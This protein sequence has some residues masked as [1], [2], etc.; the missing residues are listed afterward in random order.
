MAPTRA[1]QVGF[2]VKDAPDDMQLYFRPGDVVTLT[3]VP[4]EVI[5]TYLST[6]TN[7][8]VNIEMLQQR[9]VIPSTSTNPRWIPLDG[10]QFDDVE[11]SGT[12]DYTIP[13]ELIMSECAGQS[14]LCPVVFHISAVE[15][16]RANVT[17]GEEDIELPG[18]AGGYRVGIWSSVG[19]LQNGSDISPAGLSQTCDDWANLPSSKILTSRLRQLLPCP[20]TEAQ[21]IA[22]VQFRREVMS[23]IVGNS[24][25]GYSDAAMRFFY[26]GASV[27]Y[28]QVVMAGRYA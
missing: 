27:C 14:D 10:T 22:D 18:S 24:D 2:S 26:S 11:N 25:T 20:P 7:F 16:T 9:D 21:A 13:T 19:Y 28:L 8:R 3:W 23:S 1:H 4:S 12:F 6:N 17:G 15:G 5:Q